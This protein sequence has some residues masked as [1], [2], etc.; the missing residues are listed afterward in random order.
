MPGVHHHFKSLC[1]L[2]LGLLML[3]WPAKAVTGVELDIQ[4]DFLGLGGIVQRGVWTPVRLDL[5]NVGADNIEVTCR[6]LLQDDDGDQLIAER[7]NIALTPQR[8]TSVWL[9]ANPPMSTRPDQTWVFQA[10]AT[11]SGEL[12]KQVQLQLSSSSIVESSVNLVGLCGFKGLGLDPWTRWSTQHEQLR[13]VRGLNIQ[14]LPDRWYGLDGLSSLVWFPV[15]GGEPTS[16]LMSDQTKRALREW[17]YRGGHL[18]LVLPYGGQQ[19]TSADS[20]LSDLI[21]PLKPSAIVQTQALPPFSIFGVLPTSPKPAPVP[22]LWFDLSNAPGYTAM[23]EVDL[24]TGSSSPSPQDLRPLIVGRRYGFGQVTLVGIDLSDPTVLKSIDAFALHKV[25]TRIFNWRGSKIGQLLPPSEFENQQTA[26]QY[27]EAK[28][29]Q[30][31][32][33]GTWIAS[34]VARQRDTG[35]AVGLAFIL[36]IIYAIAAALTFPNLL[37]SRGYDRHSWVLFT[38]IVALFSVIAWGGAWV[39]RPATSSAAHFT[40]LDIDGN[41]NIVHAHSWQ[42]ILIPSFTNANIAVPADNAGLSRMDGVN[43]LSSPGFTLAAA[44]PGYPDQQSYTFDAS[45]PSTLDVP[46][47][48]TTKSMI[49]DYLGQITAPSDAMPRPWLMPTA[50]LRLANNGLPAGTITHRFPG[51]L[52][53]VKIIFCP[54]GAQQATPPGNPFPPGRPMV[55]EYRDANNEAVW[56]PNTP[57]ALPASVQFYTALWI[58]PNNSLKERDWN[59]EG[60]LGPYTEQGITSNSASDSTIVKDLILLSFFDALP[61]PVYEVQSS[62]PGFGSGDYNTYSRSLV[63][64]TDLTKLITGRRIILIGHL[65]SGPSPVPMTIDG[66]AV[67]SEGWTVVRWIYD[68]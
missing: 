28:N 18:V 56:Q 10:V 3:A 43:V 9:Y 23:G 1:C 31:H 47:R 65:R 15:E 51:P 7:P 67:D 27:Y 29:A 16:T 19:W 35:P 68:F 33:L 60:Y 53:D 25:W 52:T 22:M 11:Q 8:P 13:L 36:F 40:V 17:V 6:W 57:L 45:G 37:R 59:N 24:A 32:E 62:F 12:L 48:S 5:T 54:G 66:Q 63:R 50:A 61:P 30:H 44:S 41:T 20:G 46:M 39:M 2:A 58:T 64:D 42:S 21:E 38:G 49:V 55:Y 4:R 34:K 14:T 26:H